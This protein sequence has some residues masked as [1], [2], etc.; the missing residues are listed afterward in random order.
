M[1]RNNCNSLE[2][3]SFYSIKLFVEHKKGDEKWKKI[4]QV[5]VYISRNGNCQECLRLD[6]FCILFSFSILVALHYGRAHSFFFCFSLYHFLPAQSFEL[7]LEREYDNCN[8]KRYTTMDSARQKEPMKQIKKNEKEKLNDFFPLSN[9]NDNRRR[10]NLQTC[11][12]FQ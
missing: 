7:F 5:F 11:Y 12:M 1:P 10:I 3:I 6:L 8:L 4:Y 9:V 2:F